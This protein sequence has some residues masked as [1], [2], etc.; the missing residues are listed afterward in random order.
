MGFSA[1]RSGCARYL[2]GAY[3]LPA[4]S[5]SFKKGESRRRSQELGVRR[6]WVSLKEYRT[7]KTLR[8]EPVTQPFPGSKRYWLR[9]DGHN[10][11]HLPEAS[12][13]TVFHRLRIWLVKQPHHS[14]PVRAAPSRRLQ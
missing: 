4:K 3:D 2:Y 10:A 1:R 6:W 11:T 9:V 13:T 7:G 8:V 12:L 14:A 5:F